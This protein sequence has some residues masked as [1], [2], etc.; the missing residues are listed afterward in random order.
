MPK[1]EARISDPMSAAT[2]GN[3]KARLPRCIGTTRSQPEGTEKKKKKILSLFPL[4][5]I[6][7]MFTIVLVAFFTRIKKK[8]GEVHRQTL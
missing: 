2:Y 5:M 6:K 7:T 3:G 8:G 4:D 1:I